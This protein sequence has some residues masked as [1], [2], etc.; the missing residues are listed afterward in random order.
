[1]LAE[2]QGEISV[3]T[4]LVEKGRALAQES[5]D[6]LVLALVAYSD[7]MLALFSG[8]LGRAP[9]LLHRA[10]ETF[11]AQK[12]HP[13]HI[14]AL[15]V[16]G[17]SH[18]LLGETDDAVK[19]Y[20]QVLATT[21]ARGESLYHA[22][23][24]WGLGVVAWRQNDGLRAARLLAQAL[25]LARQV[26][27]P[28]TVA[29]C[30]EALGWLAAGERD[31]HR[32]IVLIAAAESLGHSIGSSGVVF[33]TMLAHHEH[34]EQSSRRAL[35]ER[36]YEAA[37]REG[38]SLGLDAAIAYALGEPAPTSSA[39]ETSPKLTKRERQVAEL[40]AAWVVEQSGSGH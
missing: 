15:H 26:N 19:C 3:G 40:V 34:C 10:V 38:C 30:L 7:G 1:V 21:E 8:D 12:N 18:E 25:R 5:T 28:R 23:A 13:L 27:N 16:L 9:S 39:P 20:E 6:P 32:A 29:T 36:A 37:R 4:A 11:A 14:G 35:G 2:L 24:L 17:I 22:Y 33:P 31:A